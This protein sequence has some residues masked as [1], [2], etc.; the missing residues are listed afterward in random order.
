MHVNPYVKDFLDHFTEKRVE[1]DILPNVVR[2]S[3]HQPF[4]LRPGEIPTF[5]NFFLREIMYS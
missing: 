2:L 1:I 3:T 4:I 5:S